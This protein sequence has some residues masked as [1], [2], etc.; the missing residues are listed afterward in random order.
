M[1]RF[2]GEE[3]AER[4]SWLMERIDVQV[5]QIRDELIN[6]NCW[7]ELSPERREYIQSFADSA[8]QPS[9]FRDNEMGRNCGACLNYDIDFTDDELCEGCCASRG[10][11]PNTPEGNEAGSTRPFGPYSPPGSTTGLDIPLPWDPPA[12]YD[13]F[14]NHLPAEGG[15]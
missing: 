9:D 2:H 8:M 11:G 14:L 13:N 3:F 12:D 4:R 15:P 7:E 6:Q 1:T 10:I 5:A